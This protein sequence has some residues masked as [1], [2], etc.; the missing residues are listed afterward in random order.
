VARQASSLEV[1]LPS[2]TWIP[3]L[4]RSA[5]GLA[6][7][8][9]GEDDS[10]GLTKLNDLIA[11]RAGAAPQRAQA[12]RADSDQTDPAAVQV[13]TLTAPDGDVCQFVAA[14][15]LKGSYPDAFALR[16]DGE[17]MAPD[18]R[19]GDLV[20]LSGSQPAWQG[21]PAVVQ[22]RQQIG[23]TCKI[24]RQDGPTVHLI[25]VNE[26]FPAQTCPADQVVWALRVLARVRL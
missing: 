23:V 9:S 21:R 13:I 6:Q 10:V 3:V 14:P 25:P 16:I 11:Q 1:Q 17:S 22:L 20:I 24:F 8:W 15:G 18:I 12:A 7:F 4:G 19:H 5:A 26:Q 2:N